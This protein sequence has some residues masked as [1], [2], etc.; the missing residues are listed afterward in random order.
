M[1]FIISHSFFKFLI[2]AILFSCAANLKVHGTHIRAGE[3]VV[4]RASNSSLTYIFSIIG[5]TDTGSTVEFGGGEIDFGDGTT[6]R[7]LDIGTQG[8]YYIIEDQVAYNIFEVTHTFQGPGRYTVRYT[9]QNRNAGVQNMSNSVDTPFYIESEVL[10]DPF[11]GFN[12]SPSFLIPPIDH[13]AVHGAFLH[14]P[15]A[16][17]QDGDSLS[18]RLT[19]PKQF[20]DRPVNDYK[21]PN[22][23][24]FYDNYSEGNQ[25]GDGPPTFEI[26]S[27]S[28]LLTWD[29]PGRMGEYNIAFVV[30]EWRKIENSWYNIGSITRDMQVIIEETDNLPPV[31]QE[32]EPTCVEAGQFIEQ[33]IVALDPDNDPV[34]MQPFGGPF[35]VEE[36]PATYDPSPPEFRQSPSVKI[37]WQ[38]VCSH[39]RERAYEVQ[40]KA[41]DQPPIGPKLVDFQTWEITVVGPAP[42]GLQSTLSAG[43]SVQLDWDPYN[44]GSSDQMEIWRRVDSYEIG[45]EN[46]VVGMPAN[47]GYKM[48]GTIPSLGPGNVPVTTFLDDNDGLGLAPGALYCYRIVARFPSPAGGYSYVSNEACE[49]VE[50]I[51]PVPL[52]VDIVKTDEVDGE[53]FVKWE[54]PF[55]LDPVDFPQPFSYEVVR[56]TGQSGYNNRDTVASLSSKE[57]LDVELNTLNES[58][59]YLIYAYDANGVFIDTSFPASSVRLVAQSGVTDINLSWSATVPWSNVS[60]D[61]PLHDVFRAVDDGF[62][63]LTFELIGSANVTLEGLNFIDDGSFNNEPLDD[64]IIYYYYVETK[65]T[66][67]NVA[68]TEPLLNKSQ[69]VAAQPNDLDPPCTPVSFQESNSFDCEAFLATRGCDYSDFSVTLEWQQDGESVCDNDINSYNIYYAQADSTGGLPLLANV[70]GL[71]FIHENKQSF[72]GYYQIASVDRSGNVSPKSE[73][74][75]IDNCPNIKMPNAFSPN[76]DGINDTYTPYIN[77]FIG[78]PEGG[79]PGIP[80]FDNAD[81]MR[82]VLR[83]QFKVFDR[84]GTVL[85]T[86]DSSDGNGESA[87][88]FYINWDGKTNWGRELPS[89]TYYYS[90]D[91]VFD[92]LDP[93]LQTQSYNGWIQI[94]R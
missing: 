75:I 80:G 21:D 2:F 3:I 1:K 34:E 31:I 45:Q 54:E 7:L 61:Y 36:S 4:R 6:E 51:A 17:D 62:G 74:L 81:C 48:I 78:G 63:E 33:T 40:I 49:P 56:H 69:V 94:V 32:I 9:E 70:K 28:G 22:D 82:F 57:Y 86:F 46:C 38:T 8:P 92:A 15:G 58:Y 73:I 93:S 67:G 72:K 43:R 64:E 42:T 26:D 89:G 25:E 41:R 29:A 66:Y 47:A 76:G 30:D 12:N 59:H 19:I 84:T 20:F 23:R 55:D 14:N 37:E 11:V 53:I 87:N 13:G 27:I 68:F 39:V 65:G 85:F 10:I 52:N 79:A 91:M 24:S 35:E 71:S 77:D 88:E 90:L 60:D 5:Y 44:C 50:V 16:Y 83:L 18:Y